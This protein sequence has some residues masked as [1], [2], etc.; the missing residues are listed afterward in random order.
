MSQDCSVLPFA[1]F[2]CSVGMAGAVGWGGME[3]LAFAAGRGL[4]T[5]GCPAKP[6][7][8]QV[9]LC[10]QPQTPEAQFLGSSTPYWQV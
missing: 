3:E 1:P 8:P 7:C 6:E 9:H 10:S 5:P 2:A 4:S